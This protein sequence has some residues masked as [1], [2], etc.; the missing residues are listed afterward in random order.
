MGAKNAVL[1]LLAACVLVRQPVV[2]SGCPDLSDV[3]NMLRLLESLGCSARREGAELYI[4]ASGAQEHVMPEAISKLMR[5]SIFMLG[6][7]LARFG[8]ADFTY[9]GGC[10]IGLRP[11]DLHLQ[12][13]RALGAHIEEA[14]GHI[15][16]SGKLRGGSVHLD[17]PSVGATE[18]VMMAAVGA[19]GDTVIHNAAREPEIVDLAGFLN[20][21]GGC[22]R[23]AGTD[24]VMIRGGAELHGVQYAPVADRITAGTLLLAGAATQGD[25]FVRGAR[26]QD[27]QALLAKLHEAGCDVRVYDDGVRAALHG[28]PRAVR[29]VETAPFPGFP[30]DM[31]AQMLALAARAR[32]TSVLTENVF[33]NRFNHVPD[34]CRMGADIIVA[35]RTA[36]VRGA[37]ALHGARVTAH[38]LRGGAALVLAALSAEGESVV[39]DVGHI[40]RGYESLEKELNALG[41]KIERTER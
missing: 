8:R 41:A 14:H 7:V 2:F 25:V 19:A 5:S 6:P 1:P 40:D 35:G 23:G 17:Y 16:C 28:R 33:E 13:L 3:R 24:T 12:G 29:R 37:D 34:L 15:L 20:A 38:D 31:Q 18:N 9:P 30:T 36:I 32:G 11:I 39:E 4:D 10:E 27:M 26:A 22:V 21:C